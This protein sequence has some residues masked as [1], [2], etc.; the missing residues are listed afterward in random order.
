MFPFLMEK[1]LTDSISF[2]FLI[3]RLQGEPSFNLFGFLMCIGATAARALKTV[4]QGILLS[5]EG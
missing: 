2:V 5:S 3:T 1:S 4:V